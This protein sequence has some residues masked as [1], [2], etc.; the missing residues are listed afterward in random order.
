[1]SG[2]SIE[3]EELNVS[4][5]EFSTMSGDSI[6]V[7]ELNVSTIEFSTISGD[8]IEVEELNVSTIEFSTMSGDSIEVDELNVSTIEFS[9]MNGGIIEADVINVS[10]LR[11]STISSA[12]A[13]VSNRQIR[14]VGPSGQRNALDGS[15]PLIDLD[16]ELGPFL[17]IAGN[18]DNVV[19]CTNFRF[20][21]QLYLQTSGTG[22]LTFSTG[23]GVSSITMEKAQGIIHFICDGFHMIELARSKWAHTF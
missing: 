11:T 15:D 6:E 10:T 14:P 18:G 13:I 21:D 12:G 8:S 19:T 2:D 17:Y 23:F 20:C 16:I 1:M 4:T 3:V 5:I 9:T 22:E 7:E